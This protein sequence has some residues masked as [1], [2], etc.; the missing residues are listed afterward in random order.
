MS[1][2]KFITKFKNFKFLLIFRL[3]PWKKIYNSAY[4]LSIFFWLGIWYES[5]VWVIMGWWG[6]LSE[7]RR[8]SLNWY[9]TV[10]EI[11]SCERQII[12][13][14]SYSI[15]WLLISWWLKWFRALATRVLTYSARLSYHILASQRFL[16]DDEPSVIHLWVGLGAFQRWWPPSAMWMGP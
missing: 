2:V 8:S 1:R 9:G 15:T 6:V 10:R 3:S 13:H 16:T 7:R 14:T 12:F 5:I 4:I 11:I